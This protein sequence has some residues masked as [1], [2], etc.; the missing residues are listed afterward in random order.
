MYTVL[1]PFS[2]NAL[3][4]SKFDHWTW[5]RM[6][7]FR[8]VFTFQMTLVSIQTVLMNVTMASSTQ[9]SKTLLKPAKKL[10]SLGQRHINI[11]KNA[12]LHKIL[13]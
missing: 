8:S 5:G 6:L 2:Y 9:N 13:T 3:K 1:R 4:S 10:V 11:T 7:Y 12:G